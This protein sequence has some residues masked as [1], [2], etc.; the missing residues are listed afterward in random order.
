MT[1]NPKR[2]RLRFPPVSCDSDP[3]DKWVIP[4]LIGVPAAFFAV[5]A[6]WIWVWNQ[7]LAWWTP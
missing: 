6:A 7:A 4:I 5:V 2:D 3:L 1:L